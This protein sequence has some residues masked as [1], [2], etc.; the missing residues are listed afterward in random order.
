MSELNV[1]TD[2]SGKWSEEEQQILKEG[3]PDEKEKLKKN[4]TNRTWNAIKLKAM[5]LGLSRDQEEYRH[6][7]EVR[8][9]LKE[10]TEENKIEINWDEKIIISY[11]LGVLDGDGF[12][13]NKGTLGLETVSEDFAVKFSSS[14]SNVG[15]NSTLGSRKGG[16][17]A[18]WASSIDFQ[19]WYDELSYQNKFEWLDEND[20][21][22]SYIEGAYY[23]DGD[24]SLPS[25][26][27]C[28]YDDKEKKFLKKILT[29]LGVECTIQQNNVYVRM[30]SKEKFFDN[31]NPVY[32]KRTP[33]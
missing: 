33:N 3:Y 19:K 21:F 31:V 9:K 11:I 12:T 8:E 5:D 10:L 32:D 25:P 22:W 13:G 1:E 7:E 28:S 18:V 4:L 30:K 16:K 14:L 27:I 6:S 29:K 23:S 2:R 24:L 17:S 26:R 15:F 20:G